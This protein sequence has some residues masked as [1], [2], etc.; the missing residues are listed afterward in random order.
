[1]SFD[2]YISKHIN[3]GGGNMAHKSKFLTPQNVLLSWYYL[4]VGGESE[5]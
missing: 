3:M 2:E 1:M 5:G 4:H